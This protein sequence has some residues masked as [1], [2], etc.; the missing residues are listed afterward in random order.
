VGKRG[1][2]ERREEM[3]VRGEGLDFGGGWLK[4][5]LCFVLSYQGVIRIH[6]KRGCHVMKGSSKHSFKIL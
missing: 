3:L 4:G 1:E 6:L 5:V 2:E